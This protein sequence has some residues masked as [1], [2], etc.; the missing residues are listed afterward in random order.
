M[1]KECLNSEDRNI[2][3]DENER[4]L[5]WL[6]C[7]QTAIKTLVAMLKAFDPLNVR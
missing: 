2:A 6:S 4:L 3:Q 1:E 7:H 5:A